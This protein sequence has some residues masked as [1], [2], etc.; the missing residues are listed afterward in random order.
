L[1]PSAYGVYLFQYI[2]ILWLQYAVYGLSLPAGAKFAIVL[3]GTLSISW[4]FTVLIRKIPVVAR[5][6]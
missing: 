5:M 1:R 6:I 4:S 3:V 2:P